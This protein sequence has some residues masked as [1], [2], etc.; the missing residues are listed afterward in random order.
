MRLRKLAAVFGAAA[1]TFG[2]VGAVSATAP[3]H[4]KI[5]ICHATSSETN[6][7]TSPTVDIASAGYPD[8]T[9]G[10]AS[11][12]RDGVWYPG[13]KADGFDWGDIIPPYT[14][15]DFQ[16]RRPE[17]DRRGPGDLEQRLQRSERDARSSH[18]HREDPVGDDASR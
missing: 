16:L 6:P 3:T 12:G 14:Y 18:P 4:H 10:H 17:L 7:Y 11:H 1:L 15:D 13:A 9:S 2:A 8:N 5:T